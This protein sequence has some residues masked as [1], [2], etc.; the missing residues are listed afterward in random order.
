MFSGF[1]FGVGVT[2]TELHPALPPVRFATTRDR[3]CRH[4][5]EGA[6]RPGRGLW[7]TR[8]L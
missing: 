5:L 6:E 2:L 3:T 8:A 1:G 4:R 7:P